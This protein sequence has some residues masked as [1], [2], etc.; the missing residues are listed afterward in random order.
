MCFSHHL[1][2]L[3][4]RR[5]AASKRGDQLYSEWFLLAVLEFFLPNS[6]MEPTCLVS[7]E[8]A[9][10]FFT[11]CT[12]WKAQD[13]QVDCVIWDLDVLRIIL[14]SSKLNKGIVGLG[15]LSVGISTDCS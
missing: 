7:P 15:H 8:L 6:G 13:T 9:G 1:I 4:T 3:N 14:C 11:I 12:T 2:Y 10:R 5:I